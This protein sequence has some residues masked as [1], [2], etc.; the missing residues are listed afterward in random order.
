MT[1]KEWYKNRIIWKANK[2]KLLEKNC[3][4]F[5]ELCPQQKKV[6]KMSIAPNEEE[7]VLVFW[8]SEALWTVL[9]VSSVY[10]FYHNSLNYLSLD[11]I[12]KNVSVTGEKNTVEFIELNNKAKIWAPCGTELFALMNILM[13]FPLVHDN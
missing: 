8:G 5:D 3:K 4:L 13:M 9:T 12:E 2:H 11:E 10:S 1:K 7:V 6:I